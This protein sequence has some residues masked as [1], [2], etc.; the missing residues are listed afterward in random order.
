VM[1]GGVILVVAGGTA[2]APAMITG[3]WSKYT[4]VPV[5]RGVL[6]FFKDDAEAVDQK[7]LGVGAIG[8]LTTWERLL[9]AS[10]MSQDLRWWLDATY[11]Q[12][13][14]A[15]SA[16]GG[17]GVTYIG[18]RLT[19]PRS[20]GRRSIM[21][22]QSVTAALGDECRPMLPE[23][24]EAL[25]CR[26][27]SVSDY[28]AAALEALGPKAASETPAIRQGFIEGKTTAG[29]QSS[30]RLLLA[31]KAKDRK[32]MRAIR[33][34]AVGDRNMHIRYDATL[35]LALIETDKK[36]TMDALLSLLKNGLTG[37]RSVV[38][39]ALGW[40]ANSEAGAPP[41]L[42]QHGG[43]GW[44]VTARPKA[45]MRPPVE[46]DRILGALAET[47]NDAETVVR[48][49]AATVLGGLGP[50]V[51]VVAD[52]LRKRIDVETNE[53]ARRMMISAYV[54]AEEVEVAFLL[55]ELIEQVKAEDED[56]RRWAAWSL[57]WCGK[58]AESAVPALHEAAMEDVAGREG[59]YCQA[60]GFIGGDGWRALDEL[61]RSDNPVR[62]V[63]AR[64]LGMAGTKNTEAAA[65]LL[66]AMREADADLRTAAALGLHYCEG[67]A[68]VVSA[69][70]EMVVHDGHLPA[71]RA[72]LIALGGVADIGTIV[73]VCS[74]AIRDPEERIRDLAAM[75][76][77]E[78]VQDSEAARAALAK[79]AADT[80]EQVRK[81]ANQALEGTE[82]K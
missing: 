8:T 33:S 38:V 81:A 12:R 35:A 18:G 79:A 48:L 70:S 27:Q 51:S 4:P 76:L 16:L 22:L 29:R 25:G 78:R 31:F 80:D 41:T 43:F 23:L 26:D 67:N 42:S 60:L 1:L 55:P 68:E 9:L 75:T 17:P 64:S 30:L 32:T 14:D 24:V 10:D 62:S 61:V 2:V 65:Y 50:R 46:D 74:V 82:A 36:T 57:A 56:A 7:M 72:A 15:M 3:K 40:Y 19:V 71:R 6:S 73:R 44:G 11:E 20:G 59:V 5:L 13:A 21:E 53:V 52:V 69:L 77:R 49:D 45:P 58:R 28:A 39:N 47:L 34:A 66:A 63:A 54:K 37:Q